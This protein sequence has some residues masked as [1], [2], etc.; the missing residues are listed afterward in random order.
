M[1]DQLSIFWSI[2]FPHILCLT[3]HHLQND[4]INCIYINSYNPG[5]KHCRVNHKYG[6]VTI[7]VH[8]TPPFTTDLNEF[9]NDQDTEICAVKLHFS[10]LNF[11]VLSAYRS[12]PGNFSYCL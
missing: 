12:L 9:C 8:E 6:G 1:T 7:F 3:E 5:A 4:E 11:C 10:S 2:K